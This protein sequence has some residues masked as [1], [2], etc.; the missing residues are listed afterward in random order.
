MAWHGMAWIFDLDLILSGWKQQSM[1][2]FGPAP[3]PLSR[4]G[5]SRAQACCTSHIIQ[6]VAVNKPLQT[7]ML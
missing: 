1:P 4:L 5:S 6:Y 3:A 2:R 7:V